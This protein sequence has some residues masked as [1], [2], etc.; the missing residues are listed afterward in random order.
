MVLPHPNAL[1]LT[2]PAWHSQEQDSLLQLLVKPQCPCT[3]VQHGTAIDEGDIGTKVTNIPRGINIE[4]TTG[5]QPDVTPAGNISQH[6][7][8][9]LLLLSE[10][11]HQS[12][13]VCLQGGLCP[14]Q[15]KQCTAAGLVMLHALGTGCQLLSLTV[16][17]WRSCQE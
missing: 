11:T 10:C 7:L 5:A 13:A 17:P 8:L 4:V 12:R 3:L 14:G 1:Y 16:C 9:I 6:W 15:V 2:Q